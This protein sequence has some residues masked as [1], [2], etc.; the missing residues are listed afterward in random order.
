MGKDTRTYAS[1]REYLKAAVIKRRQT[2][3]AKAVKLLGGA[4]IVCGYSK[5]PGVLDFHHIDPTTKSFGISSGGL[6]RS[7]ASIEI[8]LQKCVLVCANCHREIELGI[9]G[10]TDYLQGGCETVE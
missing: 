5:H 6:S 8:E 3:K 2:I 9:I 1:R 4:C 7:W 10:V